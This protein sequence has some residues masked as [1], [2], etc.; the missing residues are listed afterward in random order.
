MPDEDKHLKLVLEHAQ[1]KVNSYLKKHGRY[2]DEKEA[3]YV[4][5]ARNMLEGGMII[6]L[7]DKGLLRELKFHE[8]RFIPDSSGKMT[9][10]F[11]FIMAKQYGDNLSEASIRGT[12]KIAKEGKSPTNK[13]KYGYELEGRYY[14][15][16][17]DN[18][19]V[20]KEG[21]QLIADGVSLLKAS[22]HINEKGFSV[23][24]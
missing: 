4:I 10:G 9:L 7:I 13:T 11:H 3:V 19:A 16:D 23:S 2:V 8:Y 12:N 5:Y 1:N 18:F 20:L 6:D 21:L 14:R 24:R 15:P 17:E 22:K